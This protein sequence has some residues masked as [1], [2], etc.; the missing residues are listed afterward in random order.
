MKC[1]QNILLVKICHNIKLNSLE[2]LLFNLLEKSRITSVTLIDLKLQLLTHEDYPSLK[3]ISDTLDYFN[4][5]NIVANVP[6]DALSQLPASFL[7]LVSDNGQDKLVNVLQTKKG[8]TTRDEQGKRLKMS[9]ST[10]QNDWTGTLIAVEAEE[11]ENAVKSKG[12]SPIKM[13]VVFSAILFVAIL[14][15][16]NHTISSVSYIL[17]SLIGVA[18]SILI[19]KEELGFVDVITQKVCG[20]I[21]QEKA[22]CS[23]VVNSKQGKLFKGLGLGDMSLV[24]FMSMTILSAFSALSHSTLFTISLLSIPVVIYSLFVQAFQL[25]EWCVLCLVIGVILLSQSGLL[26]Y[27]HT[28]WEI[29]FFDV[30]IVLF[31]ITILFAAWQIIKGL[32]KKENQLEKVE[33]DF[34][35]FKRDREVFQSL[36][37]KN[38]VHNLKTLPASS[39]MRFGV[40]DAKIQL[41]AYTNPLC[42]FCTE[43]FKAYDKL[44]LHYPEDVSVQLIFNTPVDDTNPGTAIAKR[45]FEIYEKDKSQALDALRNWFDTK[46]VAGWNKRYGEAN[47]M[48]LQ[49]NKILQEHRELAKANEITYT[50]ETIIASYKYP[51]SQ[52]DY[53]DLTLLGNMLLELNLQEKELKSV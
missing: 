23:S 6:K 50:P 10:F 14:A 41:T 8:I 44:M 28:G 5:E 2:K 9:V 46:D 45:L 31:S 35:K 16:G 21:S 25:K 48:M 32:I 13:A 7:A 26:F 17:L 49:Y 12:I 27:T 4:I 3:A 19:V 11:K 1:C 18:A 15:L 33:T 52:Y 34:L 51:R 30:V 20:A 22:G 39:Q 47:T 37:E 53:K 43:A 36:L 40:L 38:R 24:F 42:G 29:N